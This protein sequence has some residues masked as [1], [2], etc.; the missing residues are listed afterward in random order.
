MIPVPVLTPN[1]SSYWLYFVTSVPATTAMSLVEG[2]SHDYVGDDREIRALVPQRLLTFRESVGGDARSRSGAT[3]MPAR[4]VEGSIACRDWNPTYSFYAK[5]YCGE[6]E[7]RATRESLFKV[8]QQF[9]QR[10]GLFLVP[11]AVVAATRV[12]L[13]DRRAE[14]SRRDDAIPDTLRMGDVVDGWRVLGLKPE[15]AADAVDADA[16]ARFGPAGVRDP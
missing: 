1:L 11:N 6:R 12:R 3:D 8:L 15:R 16:R 4:W 14:F 13:A 5:K 7:T 10:R 2:L 9:R